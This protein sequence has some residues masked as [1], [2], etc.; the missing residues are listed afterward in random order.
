MRICISDVRC[1]HWMCAHHTAL[2]QGKAKAVTISLS[3][4]VRRA[5]GHFCGRACAACVVLVRV[6]MSLLNARLRSPAQVVIEMLNA[7]NA[8]SENGSL[9]STPPWS[10]KYGR[11]SRVSGPSYALPNGRYLLLAITVSVSLHCLIVYVAPLANIFQVTSLDTK[12]GQ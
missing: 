7:M 2:P 4:L 6:S 10:N 1:A 8:L 11:R 9:L 12:V 3:V 5:R